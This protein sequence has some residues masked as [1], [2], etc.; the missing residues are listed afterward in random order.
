MHLKFL[1]NIFTVFIG[2]A[3]I[4]M[5]VWNNIFRSLPIKGVTIEYLDFPHAINLSFSI[6]GVYAVLVII[7]MIWKKIF[8]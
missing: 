6:T 8:Q 1:M 3:I 7:E 5:L 4:L 2:G